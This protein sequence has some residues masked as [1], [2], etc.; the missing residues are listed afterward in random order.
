TENYLTE[1]YGA[2]SDELAVRRRRQKDSEAFTGW[3]KETARLLDEVYR[4]PGQDRAAILK[5]KARIIGERAAEYATLAPLLFSSEAYADFNMGG[6]NNAF[7]DMYRLYE[8]DLSLYRSYYDRVA[9][10][11]MPKFIAGMVEMSKQARK[12]KLDIKILIAK[13]LHF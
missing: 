9:G 7:L 12:D 1:R 11:S 3:L 2:D 8:E 5:D 6:I 4:R 10:G 13:S